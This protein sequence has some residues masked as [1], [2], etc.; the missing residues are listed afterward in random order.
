M[1]SVASKE[2]MRWDSVI[3]GTD[4]GVNGELCRLQLVKL[5]GRLLSGQSCFSH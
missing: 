2:L 3:I 4:S 5:M 1:G